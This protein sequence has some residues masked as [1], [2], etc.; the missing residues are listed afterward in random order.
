MKS[1]KKRPIIDPREA[2][3]V[4]RLRNTKKL[5]TLMRKLPSV[6]L[7]RSRTKKP[8]SRPQ[9]SKKLRKVKLCQR[10]LKKPQNSAKKRKNK[11]H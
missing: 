3:R 10:S 11:S 7:L 2:S 8:Q 6:L 1:A 4:S 5:S 9:L